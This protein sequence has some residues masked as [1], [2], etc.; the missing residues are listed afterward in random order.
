MSE[1]AIRKPE[2]VDDLMLV[3]YDQ[4]RQ[5]AAGYLHRETSQLLLEP[6]ALVHEVYLR[7][8]SAPDLDCKNSMHFFAIAAVAMR[9]VLIDHA[10][11]RRALKRDL[12][13][14]RLSLDL[15]TTTGRR[16][17]DILEV[18]DALHKL[19]SLHPRWSRIIELRFFAG[20]SHDQVSSVLGVSRKTVVQD[21]GRARQWLAA[22]LSA[23]DMR[24]DGTSAA[25]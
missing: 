17:V 15:V 1:R 25:P 13:G 4:L 11:Q 6:A 20:L 7:L 10:R 22:E 5:L 23:G 9:R 2:D 19:A 24:S 21:W 3:V 18:D 12:S 8:A 16:A 14:S